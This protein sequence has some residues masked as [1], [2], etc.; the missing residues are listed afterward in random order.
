MIY[1]FFRKNNNEHYEIIIISYLQQQYIKYILFNY[2]HFYINS[3]QGIYAINVE[4]HIKDDD[5]IKIYNFL[6]AQSVLLIQ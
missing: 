4:G 5:L 3:N 1:K 6:N 2:N